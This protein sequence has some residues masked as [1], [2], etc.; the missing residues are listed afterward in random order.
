MIN[1]VMAKTGTK[2]ETTKPAIIS[3]SRERRQLGSHASER[4]KYHNI[5]FSVTL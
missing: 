1:K 2:V 3:P 4:G 5:L